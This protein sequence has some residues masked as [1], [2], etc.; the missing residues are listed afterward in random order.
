VRVRLCLPGGS[1]NNLLDLLYNSNKPSNA[2]RPKGLGNTPIKKNHP[3]RKKLRFY[4]PCIFYPRPLVESV[5]FFYIPDP[6]REPLCV[7]K[8][9]RG[10]KNIVI[11]TPCF[12]PGIFRTCLDISGRF[13][14]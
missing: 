5:V 6:L 3:K 2:I 13:F 4:P 1:G 12:L 7:K 10:L 9:S 8:K 14:Y 11:C